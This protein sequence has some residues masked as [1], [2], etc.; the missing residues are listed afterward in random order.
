MNETMLKIDYQ[1][2]I[3]YRE[4]ALDKINC[5]LNTKNNKK[6]LSKAIEAINLLKLFYFDKDKTYLW[7]KILL[8]CK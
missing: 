3:Y 4:L 1:I 2:K 6:N 7:N 8:A 5:F